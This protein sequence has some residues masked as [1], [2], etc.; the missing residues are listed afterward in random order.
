MKILSMSFDGFATNVCYEEKGEVLLKTYNR[1]ISID[2]AKAD[3]SGKKKIETKKKA[4][5]VK[6]KKK[7]K[8]SIDIFVDGDTMSSD[9]LK[10]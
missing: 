8:E 7:K 5:K 9:N 10:L 2:E 4:Q 3:I 6:S 1:N